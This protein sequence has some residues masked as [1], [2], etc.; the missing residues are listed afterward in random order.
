MSLTDS[1]ESS[2]AF[3]AKPKTHKETELMIISCGRLHR[4]PASRVPGGNCRV[5]RS[6][7]NRSEGA[8]FELAVTVQK[9]LDGS[10]R[11]LMQFLTAFQQAEMHTK[12][13]V[14]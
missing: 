2:D 13:P 14:Q 5:L 3:R 8:L 10:E 1:G 12:L 9:L 6:F 11:R 7:Q 4:A